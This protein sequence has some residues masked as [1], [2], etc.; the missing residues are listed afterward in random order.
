MKVESLK[1]KPQTLDNKALTET[2]DPVLSTGLDKVLQKHPEIAS[3][4]Q[5]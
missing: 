4:I 5:A 3:A 2:A 1:K